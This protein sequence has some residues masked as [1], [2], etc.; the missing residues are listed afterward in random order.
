MHTTGC[1]E[2]VL[3]AEGSREAGVCL[4]T[5]LMQVFNRLC[6]RT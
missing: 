5:N 4:D 2:R 1:W 3:K 6:G